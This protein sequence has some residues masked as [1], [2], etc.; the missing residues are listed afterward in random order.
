MARPEPNSAGDEKAARAS[1]SRRCLA[2]Y[3]GHLRHEQLPFA[4]PAAIPPLANQSEPGRG[5]QNSDAGEGRTV[6]LPRPLNENAWGMIRAF[7]GKTDRADL[8]LRFG[9]ALDFGD[10]A[11]L[12]RFFDIGGNAG[13]LV[14]M[15]DEAGDISGILHRVLLSPSEAELAVIVRSDVKRTGIGEKLLRIAL[16]RAAKQNLKTLR[17]SVLRENGAMLRLARKIGFV[18]RKPCGFSVELELD[19]RQGGISSAR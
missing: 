4:A 19:L 2:V 12:K 13:E 17:A 1:A 5:W 11:T 10:A 7:V 9:Q 8:R 15:L 14:C 18:P 6:V 16:S 3:M